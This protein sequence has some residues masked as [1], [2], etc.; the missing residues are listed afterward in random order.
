MSPLHP[1]KKRD[2]TCVVAVQFNLDTDGFRYRKWGSEQTCKPG[3]WLVDNNGDV[4]TVDRESFARTY[5]AVSPGLYRKTGRVWA[6][7][8]THDGTIPTKEGITHYRAGDYLVYN[9]EN[10]SDGYAV[11]AENFRAMYERIEDESGT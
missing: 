5:S 8:A 2:A 3:D 7:Q 11:K 4:Y 10:E 6:R 9:Q 1:F